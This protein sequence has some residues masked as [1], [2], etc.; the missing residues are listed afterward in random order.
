MFRG[1]EFKDISMWPPPPPGPLNLPTCSTCPVVPTAEDFKYSK[2]LPEITI[3][4]VAS[5]VW[6]EGRWTSIVSRE[7]G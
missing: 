3:P 6:R 4:M 1:I 7:G 2:D 5:G